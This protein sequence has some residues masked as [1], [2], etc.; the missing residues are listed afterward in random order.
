ME[1]VWFVFSS[2]WVWLGFVSLIAIVSGA[3]VRLVNACKRKRR[4]SG[5]RVG[6]RWSLTIEDASGEDARNAFIAV[7][8]AP[9]ESVETLAEDAGWEKKTDSAAEENEREAFHV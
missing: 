1:F 4:V 6:Q 7:T 8:C 9:G 5:Y 3:A 2:F